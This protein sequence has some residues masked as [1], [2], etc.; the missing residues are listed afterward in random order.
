MFEVSA[1]MA[2]ALGLRGPA[3]TARVSPDSLARLARWSSDG[4]KRPFGQALL[5]DADMLRR[6][7]G[8]T[9]WLVEAAE[10]GG[11]RL[12]LV[13]GACRAV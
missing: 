8:P 7:F 4:G 13:T 6:L 10:K 2:K 5:Q 11:M 9:N 3:R 12:E 1:E